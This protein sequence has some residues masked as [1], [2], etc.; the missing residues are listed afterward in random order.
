MRILQASKAREPAIYHRMANNRPVF[1]KTQ[2]LSCSESPLKCK[3]PVAFK[4]VSLLSLSMRRSKLAISSP[5]GSPMSR[6]AYSFKHPGKSWETNIAIHRRKLRSG[7]WSYPLRAFY[8]Q[9][10]QS[11]YN[12]KNCTRSVDLK[13][14]GHR[15][16]HRVL[17][18]EL[19]LQAKNKTILT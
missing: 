7:S 2:S 8:H 15:S 13:I 9:K 10:T 4:I 6:K 3:L 16:R 18:I 1:S 5:V 11:S 19:R 17:D 14:N 12:D